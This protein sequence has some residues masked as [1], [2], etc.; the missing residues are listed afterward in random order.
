MCVYVC[1]CVF[2]CVW[3]VHSVHSNRLLLILLNTTP[4]RSRNSI[5]RWEETFSLCDRRVGSVEKDVMSYRDEE[6][7][8]SSEPCCRGLF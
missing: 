6:Y 2:V 4:L 5:L 7:V 3:D 1:V 8:G